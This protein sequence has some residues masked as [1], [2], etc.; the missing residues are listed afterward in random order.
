MKLRILEHAR[1]YLS[2]GAILCCGLVAHAKESA[3]TLSQ[4]TANTITN[5]VQNPDATSTII[6]Y[7]ANK[8]VTLNLNPVTNRG[9]GGVATI[10]RANDGTRIK[11][12]L[13]NLPPD[14][15]ELTL[16]A[17]DDTGTATALGLIAIS[18]GLGTLST[19]TPLTTFMLIGSPESSL[20]VYDANTKVFFRS[21]VPEGF[22]VI[23]WR[24]SEQAKAVSTL[25]DTQ[26]SGIYNAPLLNIPAHKT[27]DD[28]KIKAAASG[29]LSG[30]RANVFITPHKDKP[31]EI[32]VRFHELKEAP[33]GTT[34]VLWAVSPDGGYV[35][36]G[37]IISGGRKETELKCETTLPDFGLL[38]TLESTNSSTPSGPAVITFHIVP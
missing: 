37:T 22:S 14:V 30:A 25:A 12:N 36:L 15:S 5:A 8:E 17:V 16:Y 20:T 19:T 38:V 18:N 2:I 1:V 11:L 31:T 27:G 21:A 3:A 4:T 7:P 9:G 24:D 35:K 28:T 32:R 26:I 6:A 23:P 33:A 13:T 29:P 34:F 10:L